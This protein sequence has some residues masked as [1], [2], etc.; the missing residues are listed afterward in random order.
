MIEEFD[1]DDGRRGDF[2]KIREWIVLSVK[3][4]ETRLRQS[5]FCRV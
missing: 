1:V 5:S 3:I 4:G 2:C